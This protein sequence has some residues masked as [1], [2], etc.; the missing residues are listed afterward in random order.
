MFYIYILKSL[1][2]HKRYIGHT[3][4]RVFERLRKHNSGSNKWTRVNGPFVVI[5][6]EEYTTKSEVVK[7][8]LFL[9]SDQ[10]RKWLDENIGDKAPQ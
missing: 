3:S 7:R 1:K 5:Y 6:S 2:N 4:K 8:E 9:K 10:G